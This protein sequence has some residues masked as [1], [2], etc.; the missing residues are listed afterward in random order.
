MKWQIGFILNTIQEL[1]EITRLSPYGRRIN[2]HLR[3][4]HTSQIKGRNPEE[5]TY[6]DESWCHMMEYMY[7]IC[8]WFCH[9]NIIKH[10]CLLWIACFWFWMCN[11]TASYDII[12]Y[13]YYDEETYRKVSPL[14]YISLMICFN[15]QYELVSINEKQYVENIHYTEKWNIFKVWMHLSC[16]KE[17]RMNTHVNTSVRN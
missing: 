2:Q 13:W 6:R 14:I 9:E 4:W 10:L 1:I 5:I 3:A 7:V 17:A 16:A 11:V 8:F 15:M 12:V